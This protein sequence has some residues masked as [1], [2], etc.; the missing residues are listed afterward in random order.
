[1]TKR[2]PLMEHMLDLGGITCGPDMG[3]PSFA[4]T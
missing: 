3:D 1:M 2:V 4:R